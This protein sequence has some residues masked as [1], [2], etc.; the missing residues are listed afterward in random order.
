[1]RAKG[2]H[3]SGAT[4]TGLGRVLVV[5]LVQPMLWRNVLLQGRGINA[6]NWLFYCIIISR[7]SFFNNVNF[8]VVNV[9][10][11]KNSG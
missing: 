3:V 8:L 7:A 10:F 1:M 6:N 5:D 11:W 9:I 4:I 2:R